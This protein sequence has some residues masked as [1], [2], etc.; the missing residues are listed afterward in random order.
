MSEPERRSVGPVDSARALA[1]PPP[2]LAWGAS[3]LLALGVGLLAVDVLGQRM[4]GHGWMPLIAGSVG[5]LLAGV[6]SA[7]SPAVPAASRVDKRERRVALLVALWVAFQ[8]ALPLRYYFREDPYDER[9]S[10]R[11]FSAVRMQRCTLSVFERVD[12][13]EREIDLDRTIHVAWINMLRRNRAAVIDRF[14][15]FACRRGGERV[16]FSNRC[17]EPDGEAAPP[18]VVTRV[19][20]RSGPDR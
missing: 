15:D 11:M 14:L 4:D 20:K 7:L 18:V 5:L 16:R 3:F 6:W 9:F 13:A 8:V 12:G 1:P 19:C 2:A 17:V 10:W